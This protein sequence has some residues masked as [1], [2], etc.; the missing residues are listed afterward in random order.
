MALSFNL[1]LSAQPP[2]FEAAQENVNDY[3]NS[4]RLDD[5]S[6]DLHNCHAG[7]QRQVMSPSD[8]LNTNIQRAWL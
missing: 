8:H 4:E 2:L 5:A 6:G 7:I 3:C 1:F